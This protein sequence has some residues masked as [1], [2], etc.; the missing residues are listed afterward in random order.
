M[1]VLKQQRIQSKSYALV[2]NRK[3]KSNVVVCSF[4]C[5]VMADLLTLNL[6]K[7]V[8]H[9]RLTGIDLDQASLYSAQDLATLKGK[10]SLCQFFRENAWDLALN[11]PGEFDHEFCT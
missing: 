9:V 1:M 5:G 2:S 3:I 8:T 10:N 11:H 7:K 4:P 6:P